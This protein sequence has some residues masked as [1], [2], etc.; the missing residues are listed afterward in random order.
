MTTGNPS[1]LRSKHP[2][3]GDQGVR[4]VDETGIALVGCCQNIGGIVGKR[5]RAIGELST[6]PSNRAPAL[7]K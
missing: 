1:R 7:P 6:R 2:R 3:R 4:R 5:Q